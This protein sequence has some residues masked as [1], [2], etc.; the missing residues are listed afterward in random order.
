MLSDVTSLVYAIAMLVI[1]NRE[2]DHTHM[3]M[4][5]C[6]TKFHNSSKVTAL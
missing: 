2:K 5:C 4:V 1:F 6:I 3:V